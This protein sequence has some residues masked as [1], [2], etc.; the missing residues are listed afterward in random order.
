MPGLIAPFRVFVGAIAGS[1]AAITE[2]NAADLSFLC[3]DSSK[4]VADS[5]S[6]HPS[7]SPGFAPV[8]ADRLLSQEQAICLL[9]REVSWRLSVCRTM[10]HR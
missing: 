8:M 6:G 1:E 10:F 5:Q 7:L 2:A 4:A 3:A 9:G